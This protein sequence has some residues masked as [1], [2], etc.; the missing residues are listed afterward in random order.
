MSDI[1]SK[2]LQELPVIKEAPI[3]FFGAVIAALVVLVPLIWFFITSIN[4]STI[5]SKDAIIA[6]LERQ[7]DDFRE[8]W[9]RS[10]AGKP[11]SNVDHE[12]RK[13]VRIA[14]AAFLTE[15]QTLMQR[16]TNGETPIPTNDAN[17]WAARA[18]AYMRE[19]LDESFVARF[20]DAS[21]APPTMVSA[22]NM[23]AEH[24]NLWAGIRNRTFRLQQ[25]VKEFSD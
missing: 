3:S 7:R 1:V 12:A 15:G 18:E 19:N 24:Q 14:L 8:Q 13:K 22:P 20:R 9:A 16:C 10:V 25:F 11:V 23:T 2:W 21:D 17:A 6:L 4:S 5:A